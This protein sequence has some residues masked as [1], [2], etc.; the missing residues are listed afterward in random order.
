MAT[1]SFSHLLSNLFAGLCKGSIRLRPYSDEFRRSLKYEVFGFET[2]FALPSGGQ[3]NP[4][5]VIV[6]EGVKS[7][8]VIEWTQ[9]LSVTAKKEGQLERYSR[10]D[11]EALVDVLA[12]PPSVASSH[13][14][15]LILKQSAVTSFKEFLTNSGWAFPILEFDDE[16]GYSL[17]RVVHSFA[18]KDTDEFFKRGVKV[19]SIPLGY[20]PFSLEEISHETIVAFV[21]RHLISLIV[22]GA[23]EITTEEFCAGYVRL[24]QSIASNK[25]KDI[26]TKTRRLLAEISGN[27]TGKQI[28]KRHDED[29]LKW[30]LDHDSVFASKR[31]SFQ[32]YLTT[33][34]TRKEGR[35]YQL[36]L[37]FEEP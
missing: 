5:L 7:T 35:E 31:R 24:W 30:L 22:R 12:V 28:L 9:A 32:T 25:Q 36:E 2:V 14:V 13:N 33:F 4:D 29:S 11:R 17:V 20:I 8:L 10:V 23:K 6:S 19:D 3:A 18:D 16:N 26:K 34:V 37:P 1:S 27:P 15:V 21:V